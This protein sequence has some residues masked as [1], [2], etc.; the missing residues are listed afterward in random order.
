[1]LEIVKQSESAEQLFKVNS[2]AKSPE[3]SEIN[4]E[5]VAPSMGAKLLLQS[6]H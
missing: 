4:V 5:L 1:M 2:T 6:T 3:F